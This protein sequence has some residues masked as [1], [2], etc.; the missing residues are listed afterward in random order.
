MNKR[1]QLLHAVATFLI[2]MGFGVSAWAQEIGIMQSSLT[3]AKAGEK[4]GLYL[5]LS[6]EFDLPRAVKDALLRG[7]A[8]YFVTDFVLEKTRW[9]WM[10]QPQSET[11]LVTRLSYS[12]LTR[13]YRVSRGGLSQSFDTLKS[14]L[15]AIKIITDWRVSDKTHISTPKDFEAEV[16]FRLDT[17]QLPLPMQVSIGN[18]DWDL[19]SDWHSIVLDNRVSSSEE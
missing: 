16:R 6:V 5:S 4:P 3:S 12:P 9:Y 15:D 2:G 11:S 7:I 8:L 13:Q 18:N 10:D 1:A 17:Q 19:S 14:A